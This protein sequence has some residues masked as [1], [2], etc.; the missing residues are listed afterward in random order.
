MLYGWLQGFGAFG[1]LGCLAACGQVASNADPCAPTPAGLVARWRGEMTAKDDTGRYDGTGVG[2]LAYT[3]GGRHGAAF[4]LDGT[5][6]AVSVPD[7]D[8]LWPASSFS[9]EG[10]V[11]ASAAGSMIQKYECG[12]ACP[13]GTSATSAYW[14][15]GIA[16]GG[17]PTFQLRVN[18]TPDAVVTT[19]SQ[20]VITDGAWHHLAG[21]RDIRAKQ[22]SL[23]LDGALAVSMPLS[24]AQLGPLSNT[25]GEIDPV[26]IGAA[27]ISLA[28][29]YEHFLAGAIDEVAYFSSAL[30]AQEVQAI[31]AAPD[32]E[33]P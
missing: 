16:D 3:P 13:G 5:S 29:G 6:A 27:A 24:D 7:G 26:V 14:Q 11:K 17:F 2:P 1:L 33:C 12:G 18:R 9:L 31:Y 28:P 19:D 23:Y 22:I 20:D 8:E 4:L 15:L 30:T 21:V 25:D 32:G 10:W